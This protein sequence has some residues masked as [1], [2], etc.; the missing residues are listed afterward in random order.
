VGFS[1]KWYQQVLRLA[2][3][4]LGDDPVARGGRRDGQFCAHLDRDAGP[5]SSW[6][7]GACPARRRLLGFLLSPMI[8]PRLPHRGWRLF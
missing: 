3:V 5:P 6:S 8:L 1:L 2:A 4:D 7:G